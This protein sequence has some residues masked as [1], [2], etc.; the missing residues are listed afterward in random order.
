[1]P[2]GEYVPCAG[3]S[4]A[5]AASCPAATP[6]QRHPAV[7]RPP[8]ASSAWSSPGEV[9]FGTAGRDAIGHGGTV[10]LNPRTARRTGSPR[11]RASRWPRPASG[12]SRT[13][14]GCSRRRPLASA[15]WSPNDGKVVEAQRGLRA[16]GGAAPDHTREGETLATRFG[17][18]PMLLPPPA[19]WS[20]RRCC[21]VVAA[22]GADPVATGPGT[23]A[24]RR[25]H[26]PDRAHR[27]RRHRHPR[28]G[29][30]RPA[31][32]S[33]SDGLDLLVERQESP[34]R[35]GCF[36]DGP[37]GGAASATAASP[38]RAPSTSSSPS[39]RRPTPST[40]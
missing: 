5:S 24:S 7:V 28:P 32:S 11:C 39:T 15:P 35:W 6:R 29:G 27:R 37:V 8:S 21:P 2:F 26:R 3:S 20:P 33:R 19:R 13:T 4:S 10:L 22:G 25:D 36:P 34:T 23:P 17:D 14:A 38:G 30:R 16:A 18:L 31:P 12:H 1:M 9:F 40:G